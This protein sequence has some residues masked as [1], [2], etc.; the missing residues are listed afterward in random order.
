MKDL[1]IALV[2]DFLTALGGGERVLVALHEMYPNAPVYTLRYDEAGTNGQFK[3]WDIRVAPFGESFVGRRATLALPFLPNAVETLP[4]SEYDLVISSS[5]AFS[6]GV[7]TKPTTL[8]I[9]YCHTPMRF[10]WDW[11]HEYA[12]ENNYESGLR[13]IAGRLVTHYLRLWDQASVDRVD[14]WVAN[15]QNVANRIT[16][17]YR[18]NSTVIYPPVTAATETNSEQPTDEPYFL[19]VSRLSA[20]KKLDLAIEA[21][22]RLHT[23]LVIIGKGSDQARLEVLAQSL[24]APV[25]FLGYQEDSVIA[26]YYAHCRAFLFPGEDDFGITPVEAMAYGKPVIAYGKGGVLETVV[27]GKT[28]ILFSEPTV[29]SLV[30]GMEEF[31]NKEASFKVDECRKQAAQFSSDAFKKTMSAYVEKE[32]KSFNAER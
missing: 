21:A 31:M 1:N 3:D 11:T 17:Y 6:K 5:S 18:Q 7:V 9:C 32:W 13:S 30:A 10:V 16:K 15:S 8:H 20:Y 22:A 2:H 19:I 25:A 14:R 29:E 12:R 24:D 4:L 27:D 28:G 23:P 26:Q